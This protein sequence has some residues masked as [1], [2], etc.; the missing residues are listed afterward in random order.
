MSDSKQG[1]SRFKHWIRRRGAWSRISIFLL[2]IAIAWLPVAIWGY[3]I[4]PSNAKEIIALAA[5]YALFLIALPQW[6]QHIHQW[7]HPFAYCGLRV[8]KQTK[9]DFFIALMI[10][11]LGV[12]ALFGLSAL[13]GWSAYQ[14]PSPRLVR[15]I[16]EG[17]LMAI[18]VGFAEEM[19]FRGW[20]LAELELNYTPRAALLLNAMLFAAV[21]FIKPLSEIIRTSPQFFGLLLLG[22]ALV[23]ARR[24]SSYTSGDGQPSLGY[25]IGLH[26]GLI[27]GY[28]IVNV[29]GLSEPTGQVHEW[30]T[31]IN[32]NPLAGLLG[33]ILLGAIA[34]PFAKAAQ[35]KAH[36]I[37]ADTLKQPP[38]PADR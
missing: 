33:L 27:W 4:H 11:A 15:F 23:W 16:F 20:L 3:F 32:E 25:P 6:G 29:G 10:G 36:T 22:M 17:L 18:A 28:Y 2:L 21:H 24:S 30:L 34:L 35:P 8:T 14:S 26:A 37:S 7:T 31:G 9:R 12:F 38:Q 1:W 19:L 13:L 5:L